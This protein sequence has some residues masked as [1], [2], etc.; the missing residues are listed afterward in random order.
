M[1]YDD[2]PPVSVSL[3]S[4]LE[5]SEKKSTI[6]R[7]IDDFGSYSLPMLSLLPHR[8]TVSRSP[9]FLGFTFSKFLPPCFTQLLQTFSLEFLIIMGSEQSIGKEIEVNVKEEDVGKVIGKR[10]SVLKSIETESGAKISIKNGKIKIVSESS[11]STSAAYRKIMR[12][13]NPPTIKIDFDPTQAGRVIGP[14]GSTIKRIQH[15]TET[16]V[17]IDTRG[18]MITIRGETQ[19]RVHDAEHMIM[20]ILHP[21]TL[22]LRCDPKV[23]GRVIGPKGATIKRIQSDSGARVS[24]DKQSGMI[25]IVGQDDMQVRRARAMIVAIVQAPSMEISC[26]REALGQ[27]IG[28]RGSHI[29]AVQKDTRTVIEVIDT[30]TPG[31]VKL[32]IT[33]SNVKDMKLA[34]TLLQEEIKAAMSAPD[35]TGKEGA[36]LRAE[37]SEW[38]VKREHLFDSAHEAYEKGNRDEAKRLSEEGK[39]A[40]QNMLKLN[41]LASAAI[42]KHLNKSG[43]SNY[44][45]LHGQ[46]VE[47]AL[48][49]LR[50]RLTMLLSNGHEDKLHCIVGAGHHSKNHVARI[51]P[52]VHKLIIKMGL[53]Y[54]VDN[55]GK[56][57]IFA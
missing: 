51:K 1:L 45:D 3:Y 33:S 6:F 37:A 43:N 42:F 27:I 32:K 22:H 18:A 40:T 54:E 16:N 20:S 5:T 38:A 55:V 12:I 28:T 23:F 25:E 2:N 30:H 52:A 47:E 4:I 17:D 48:D 34:S 57:L 24:L 9:T 21:P 7:T 13:I 36:R 29:K 31:A 10:G 56:Y 39:I 46:F 41:A 26:P 53:R 15:D 19:E 14:R 49:L 8:H 11:D 35:Y 50:E 44:I